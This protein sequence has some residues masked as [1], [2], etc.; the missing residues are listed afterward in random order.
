MAAAA[1]VVLVGSVTPTAAGPAGVL[2]VFALL[3]VVVLGVVT[4]LLRAIVRVGQVVTRSEVTRRRLAGVS[5]RQSYYYAS[6]I[7][8]GVVV[9][10]GMRSVGTI[11]VYEALL[12]AM[13]VGLG[14][15]YVGRTLS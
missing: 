10:L 13:L 11:G 12:V 5:F 6:V 7:A 15:L 2:A 9:L 8:L 4:W 1:L 14:C 3:Y